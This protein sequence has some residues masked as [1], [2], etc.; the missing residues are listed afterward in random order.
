L[1]GPARTV[2]SFIGMALAGGCL[3][4]GTAIWLGCGRDVAARLW[5]VV[6]RRPRPA[7]AV[8]RD[9]TFAYAPAIAVGVL[10]TVLR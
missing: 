5:A 6:R 7:H 1:L 9:F 4:V 3:A 2:E 8:R 10:L